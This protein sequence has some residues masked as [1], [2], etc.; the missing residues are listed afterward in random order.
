MISKIFCKGKIVKRTWRTV[1]KLNTFS[2]MKNSLHF[3]IF[4]HS[5]LTS[6]VFIMQHEMKNQCLE[7]TDLEAAFQRYNIF[8]A[9]GNK[10]T[11]DCFVNSENTESTLA[12]TSWMPYTLKVECSPSIKLWLWILVCW[13]NWNIVKTLCENIQRIKTYTSASIANFKKRKIC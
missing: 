11:E 12:I 4:P 9:S 5:S 6:E 3:H 13:V 1:L 10:I 2:F 8:I 7:T